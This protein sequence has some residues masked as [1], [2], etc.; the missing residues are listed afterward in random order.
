MPSAAFLGLPVLGQSHPRAPR[1]GG[2]IDELSLCA[3]LAPTPSSWLPP[4]AGYCT[5]LL[6]DV[7]A[8]ERQERQ[9]KGHGGLKSLSGIQQRK[10][11]N[12]SPQ[13]DVFLSVLSLLGQE[14]LPFLIDLMGFGLWGMEHSTKR[15][16]WT[17]QILR[18]LVAT[19]LG[20][21]PWFPLFQEYWFPN[22]EL[23]L[24]IP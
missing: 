13:K 19:L 7:G 22:P 18:I 10:P 4:G 5:F 6:C 24:D 3:V 12:Y 17:S 16:L 2:F 23:G 15:Y 20:F 8:R 21:V 9:E 1:H 11:V 14:N